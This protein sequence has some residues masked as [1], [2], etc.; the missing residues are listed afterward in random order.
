MVRGP[1][2]LQPLGPLAFRVEGG[3]HA[4]E[5]VVVP[6]EG[7]AVLATHGVEGGLRLG[8]LG[9]EGVGSL[10]LDAVGAAQQDEMALPHIDVDGVA[11][12]VTDLPVDAP[13]DVVELRVD[14]DHVGSPRT[15][16]NIRSVSSQGAAPRF[17][18]SSARSN[19][20]ARGPRA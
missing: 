7:L 5:G 9:G 16:T 8:E 15:R 2:G 20:S 19:T 3:L 18:A 13:D 6:P 17:A 11:A 4:G 12:P 1:P 14:G 10:A